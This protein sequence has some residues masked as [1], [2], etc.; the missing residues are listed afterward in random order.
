MNAS[1]PPVPRSDGDANTSAASVIDALEV[2]ACF[3]LEHRTITLAQL[4]AMQ[5][6]FVIELDQPLN[7]SVI[8]I[9]VNGLQVG[10]G[11]LIAVGNKLGIRVSTLGGDDESGQRADRNNG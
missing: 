2:D 11:H 3:E 8:R 4:K 10:T 7:Q 6:G 1:S 5:P 9:L